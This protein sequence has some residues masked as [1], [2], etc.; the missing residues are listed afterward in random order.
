MSGYL[1]IDI[2][3]YSDISIKDAGAYRYAECPNF[4]ILMVAYCLG[5]SPVECYDYA[6]APA[7]FFKMLTDPN[8]IKVAH[9]AAFERVCFRR[10]G[11]DIPPEQWRCT[12]IKA[13]YSGLP[14]ALAQLSDVLKLGEKGKQSTG[15]ALIRYFCSPVKATKVNGG[16][17][18]NLPHHDPEKWAEFKTYCAFD[19]EAERE[20]AKRLA[21]IKM[22]QSEWV[23]YFLDQRINDRGVKIHTDMAEAALRINAANS[24][25]LLQEVKNLTGIENPNSLP[26]LRTWIEARTGKEVKSLDKAA[27]KT[28]LAET[29]DEVVLE[30]LAIRARTGKTSI[31]KYAKMLSCKGTG[32]RARGLF[33][34][35]G[36]HTGR[37]AGRLIQLQN[38]PRNE[39]EA[40][41]EARTDLIA[42]TFSTFSLLWETSDTLS[43]LIRTALVPA[44]GRYFSVADFAAIEARVLAWLAGEK[45]RLDVFN[46][47]GKIY[48]ASASRM[49]GVPIES[50]GK[51][52]E[53]RS[54]GKVSEL[55]LGYQGSTG[56]LK[57]MGGEAMGLSDADMKLIVKKWRASNP[58]IVDFWY[59]LN[60]MAV[61]V[62]QTKGR[63]VHRRTGLEI[64]Y[65]TKADT[66]QIR[67]PSGRDLVYQQPSLTTNQF[68]QL[69][70]QYW[71]INSYTRKWEQLSTYGGKL[72]ENIVQAVARDLLLFSMHNVEDAGHDIV[73]HVHD[74]LVVETA[75]NDKLDEICEIMSRTPE[76]A[77]GLPL[78][79]EGYTGAYYKKG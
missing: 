34:F 33:Q 73:M 49:F 1:H 2:E 3:T 54:K 5:G 55:A 41:D 19:V 37:W 11:Y 32:G 14:M 78:G 46:G 35:Y 40:L 44:Q 13:A 77:E 24:E 45:W 48:E 71:G 38:L 58:K 43:Q 74:E 70:V 57:Q 50:I 17:T 62:V 36:G 23:A 42:G 20:S 7:D 31:S 8:I 21:G 39:M 76:W 59:S 4:E 22:P 16:R 60:D 47:D 28:L 29:A 25:I 61:A 30:V 26:Q 66:M 63:R 9:N 65:N 75:S 27:V 67:L 53:L 72:T 52:S 68:G 6:D 56:A 18:R 10:V 64:W 15:K 12:A 69:S 51:D 79:A